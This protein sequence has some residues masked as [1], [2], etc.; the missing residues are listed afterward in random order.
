MALEAGILT[1]TSKPSS[2][3]PARVARCGAVGEPRENKNGSKNVQ[4]QEQEQAGAGAGAGRNKNENENE[5]LSSNLPQEINKL[6]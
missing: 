5:N 6:N 2:Q 4:E 1:F 3:R